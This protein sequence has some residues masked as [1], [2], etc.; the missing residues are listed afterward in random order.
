[1]IIYMAEKRRKGNR[2]ASQMYQGERKFSEIYKGKEKVSKF[3]SGYLAVP[4]LH[5]GWNPPT[6][7]LTNQERWGALEHRGPKDEQNQREGGKN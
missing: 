3:G 2:Q 7:N 6:S 1:L 4:V 5:W